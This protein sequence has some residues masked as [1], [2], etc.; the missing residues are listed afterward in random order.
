M[1][2]LL[3]ILLAFLPFVVHAQM[4]QPVHWSGE[5]VGDSVRLTA[6]IDSGWH[7]TIIEF[8][9]RAYEQEFSDSFAVVIAKSE[10]CPIRFDHAPCGL[11]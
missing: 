11:W 4:V 10:L 7:M 9:D 2:R 8:G 5:E 6:Q 3:V 1:K